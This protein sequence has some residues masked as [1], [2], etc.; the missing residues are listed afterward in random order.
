MR[1]GD[2]ALKVGPLEDAADEDVQWGERV[3]LSRGANVLKERLLECRGCAEDEPK[4]TLRG[5]H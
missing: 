2:Q 4:R 3:S 5:G 1:L